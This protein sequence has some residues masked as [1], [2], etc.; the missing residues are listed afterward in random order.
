MLMAHLHEHAEQLYGDL[1][2]LADGGVAEVGEP[3]AVVYNT[4]LRQA[5]TDFPTDRL[6]DVL[7]PVDKAVA[8]RVLQALAGQLRLVLGAA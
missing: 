2:R 3:L 7:Q 6:I 5:K 1:G 8:P 4:L